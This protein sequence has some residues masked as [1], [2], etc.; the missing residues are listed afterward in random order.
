[1]KKIRGQKDL[2]NYSAKIA[3][4]FGEMLLVQ[5]STRRLSIGETL[6]K[7]QTFIKQTGLGVMNCDYESRKSDKQKND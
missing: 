2:V 1:M 4:E 5:F 7:G 3:L 6:S